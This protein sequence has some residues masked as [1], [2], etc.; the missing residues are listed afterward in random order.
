MVT[1]QESSGLRSDG[2]DESTGVAITPALRPPS[3][4]P[5]RV[6][7]ERL[8]RARVQQRTYPMAARRSAG[9]PAALEGGKVVPG[10]RLARS[11]ERATTRSPMCG[12]NGVSRSRHTI[13]R[14]VRLGP[15]DNL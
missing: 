8:P 13:C 5:L 12:E 1:G 15:P 7:L 11:N 10:N 3:R 9:E 4:L 2:C 6:E 14:D